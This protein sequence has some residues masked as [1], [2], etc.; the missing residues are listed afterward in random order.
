MLG[1]AAVAL[2]LIP[3]LT[4]WMANRS[5]SLSAAMGWA[6][7]AWAGW[8]AAFLQ[9]T[10]DDARYLAL[11]LTGCAGVAVLGARRPHVFAWN[12]VVFGLLGVMALPILEAFVIRVDSFN[13]ERKIFLGVILFVTI[14][15]YLPTRFALAVVAAGIGCTLAYLRIV[16]VALAPE[17]ESMTIAAVGMTPWI[18]WWSAR[19]P[20]EDEWIVLRDR[21]G[22]VWGAR[23]RDQFNAAARNAGLSA[24]IRWQGLDADAET[25]ESARLLLRKLTKRFLGRAGDEGD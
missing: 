7:V 11:C 10:S 19:V 9:P 20:A 17:S 15:N 6:I 12:F 3:L 25:E 5:T 22:F 18:A 14:A 24:R 2:G 16:G 1:V 21:Y 4:A 8:G 23:V 13:M